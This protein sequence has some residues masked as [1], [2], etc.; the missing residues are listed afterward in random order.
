[1]C[2][3]KT[4]AQKTENYKPQLKSLRIKKNRALKCANN[5]M[6]WEIYL[7]STYNCLFQV[8]MIEES[9]IYQTTRDTFGWRV[10]PLWNSSRWLKYATVKVKLQ[11]DEVLLR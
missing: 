11:V 1:M 9:R 4:S 5:Q 10:L 6:A 2:V 7:L 8:K 3:Q